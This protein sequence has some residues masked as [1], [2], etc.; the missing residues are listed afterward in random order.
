MKTQHLTLK[1]TKIQAEA[2]YNFLCQ[3]VPHEDYFNN[4]KEQNSVRQAEN[5][6]YKLIK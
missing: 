6:L 4:R 1:I 3:Y 2:L 5:K